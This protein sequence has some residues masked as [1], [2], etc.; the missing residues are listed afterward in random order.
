MTVRTR[1][2]M[3]TLALLVAVAVMLSQVMGAAA[4]D[5][6][7]ASTPPSDLT[8]TVGDD[9]IVFNWT[10]GVGDDYVGQWMIM[11]Q[12][13]VA[14]SWS[15]WLMASGVSELDYPLTE[16]SPGTTYTFQVAGA[17]ATDTQLIDEMG[18]SNTVMVVTPAQADETQSQSSL[19][20]IGLQQEEDG[21]N[22]TNV[23]PTSLKA[24]ATTDGDIRL[25]WLP[26][27]YRPGEVQVIRRRVDEV[28]PISW[29]DVEVAA[30]VSEYVDDTVE[31]GVPYI[32][33]I[34]VKQ[35]EGRIGMPSEPV[36]IVG[37]GARDT[38]FPENMLVIVIA[39]R[40]LEVGGADLVQVQ[41]VWESPEHPR[42][43]WQLMTNKA[44]PIGATASKN[45][46]L[47]GSAK[48]SV[49]RTFLQSGE[50]WNTRVLT[51]RDDFRKGRI[52]D[53]TTWTLHRPV[54]DQD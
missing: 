11:E 39:D 4:D 22:T 21:N 18:Y 19:R 28:V 36:Q 37:P 6:R 29:T 27:S 30:N 12:D 50:E 26:G 48:V 8:A 43:N 47:G 2:L 32:Y 33:R 25:V 52:G 46:L 41:F 54:G 31:P 1:G 13:G 35:N 10:A 20:K 49:L 14:A 15:S 7:P 40:V 44:S 34:A 45:V 9:A 51:F 42:Y 53:T 16:L 17:V 24:E 5:S 3:V 23:A 38:R